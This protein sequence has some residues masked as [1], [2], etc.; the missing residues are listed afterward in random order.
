MPDRTPPRRDRGRRR[1]AGVVQRVVD[2]GLAVLA[3]DP[4]RPGAWLL[5]VDGTPQSHV[6]LTDPTYLDFEYVRWLARLLDTVAPAGVPLRV[7]H[8]GGGGCTLA[9]YV[10]ATRPRSGQLVVELD[11]ALVELVR[12]HLPLP[13]A[14]V[15]VRTGDAREVLTGLRDAS[16]DAVV[17]DVFGGAR[18]PAHLTSTQYL[19]QVARVL[20]PGGVYAANLP[21]GPPL[22]F[23]REQSATLRA[24]FGHTALVGPPPVLRGRRF[25]NLVLAGS[26]APLPVAELSRAMAADPFPVRVLDQDELATFTGTARPTDDARAEPSPEPPPDLFG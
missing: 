24:V 15:R 13:R 6:D 17:G 2:R 3:P 1:P 23:A 14:G 21:D 26:A 7:L 9:R 19:E 25:G 11:G 10:A 5:S 22:R 8:L 18:V 16:Y 12:Q 4:D 20:R